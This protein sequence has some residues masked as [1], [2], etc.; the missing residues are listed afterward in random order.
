MI[1][2]WC[3]H[4][5]A[6]RR[7][8]VLIVKQDG[9]MVAAMPL[10]DRAAWGTRIGALPGNDWSPAGDLLLDPAAGVEHACDTLVEAIAVCGWPAVALDAVVGSAPRWQAFFAALERKGTVFARRQRFRINVARPGRDWNAYFAS[11]SRSHR[12]RLRRARAAAERAGTLKLVCHDPLAIA[13][14]EPLLRA[15]FEIEA[16]GWKGRAQGAVLNNERIWTFYLE[17]AR[18]LAARGSLHLVVLLLDGRPIAFEYGWCEKGVYCSPKV[19][20]DE[21]FARFAP[22]QLLRAMLLERSTRDDQIGAI[23]YLGPSSAATTSWATDDYGVDRVVV[24]AGGAMSRGAVKLYRRASPLWAAMRRALGAAPA[25]PIR[26]FAP[27]A[28]AIDEPPRA[29]VSVDE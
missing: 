24:A 23:D 20:Y 26:K 3:D 29:A 28:A 4:F 16:A 11:R 1:A 14:V 18:H 9:R 19:G 12:R 25:R 17:Q 27:T 6:G 15:C 2:L 7:L 13:D 8:A 21:A 5:A 10:V 22:G